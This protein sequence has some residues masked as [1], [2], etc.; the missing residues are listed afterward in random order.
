MQPGDL[1]IPTRSKFLYD[2]VPI[3]VTLGMVIYISEHIT[4]DVTPLLI[5][6]IGGGIDWEFID[7]WRVLE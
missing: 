5:M 4:Y 3:E 2:D 6:K 7:H 1:V